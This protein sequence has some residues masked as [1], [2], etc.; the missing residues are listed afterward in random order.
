VTN[1]S[2]TAFTAFLATVN[3]DELTGYE[4]RMYRFKQ[5]HPGMS[6]DPIV[7]DQIRAYARKKKA[8]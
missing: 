3:Y 2:D 1:P 5:A 8:A 6:Y 4:Q 7:E